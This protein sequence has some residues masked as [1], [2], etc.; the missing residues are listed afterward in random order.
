MAKTKFSTVTALTEQTTHS[1]R[2][3][4]G[5]DCDSPRKNLARVSIQFAKGF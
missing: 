5:M 4:V 3:L 2:W 1:K